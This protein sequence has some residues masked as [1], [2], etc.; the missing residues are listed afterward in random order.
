MQAA[1][2]LYHQIRNALFGEAQNLF[3][4]ATPFDPCNHVLDHYTR[5]GEEAVE[6]LISD[7]QLFAFWLFL[8][9]RVRT[10]AGS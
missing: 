1:G 6:E 7:A 8:G 2:N 10:P 4:N 9:C 3:D 5:A